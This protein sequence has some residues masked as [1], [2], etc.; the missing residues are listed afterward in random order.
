MDKEKLRK[1]VLVQEY[2]DDEVMVETPWA[3]EVGK[4]RFQLKNYPFYFYGLSFDDVF[5]A[6]PLY[7]DDE[8]P[9]F[10]KVLKN[11]VIKQS[12]LFWQTR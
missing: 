7:E 12:E 9:Y 5:E 3:E 1:V 2:D 6:K 8:R 11:Q 4:N 10:M